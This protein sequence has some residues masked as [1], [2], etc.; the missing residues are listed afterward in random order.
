[1]ICIVDMMVDP[2]ETFFI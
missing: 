1:M 2:R